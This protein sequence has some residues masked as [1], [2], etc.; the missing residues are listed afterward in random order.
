MTD[1]PRLLLLAA[2]ALFA[3]D[4]R[5]EPRP[6]TST[7]A[8]INICD[9]TPEVEAA[10][11]ESLAGQVRQTPEPNCAAGPASS[12]ARLKF[13]AMD[14]EGLTALLGDGEPPSLAG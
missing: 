11:L 12:L 9:R 13:L 14:G 2:L 3:L 4:A 10:I 1:K 6:A 7:P 8:T 5:A